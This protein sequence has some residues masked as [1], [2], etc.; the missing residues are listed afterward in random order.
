MCIIFYT[1]IHV[2]AFLNRAEQSKET[3]NFPIH[4]NLWKKQLPWDFHGRSLCC[5]SNA[6]LHAN[7]MHNGLR[8]NVVNCLDED[9]CESTPLVLLSEFQR[10]KAVRICDMT[11]LNSS[12]HLFIIFIY[13]MQCLLYI[14]V[15]WFCIVNSTETKLLVNFFFS[16]FL[17]RWGSKSEYIMILVCYCA[18]AM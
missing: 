1:R 14:V 10:S 7:A 6:F 3:N 11:L 4:S 5:N 12:L 16:V 9:I 18:I 2:V 8:N 15:N 17:S 13:D